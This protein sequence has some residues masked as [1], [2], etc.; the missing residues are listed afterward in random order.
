M[1]INE[2]Y[3][4]T[5]YLDYREEQKCEVEMVIGLLAWEQR[6]VRISLATKG[7]ESAFL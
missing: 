4:V 7:A 3:S 2:D 1:K 5:C 6:L